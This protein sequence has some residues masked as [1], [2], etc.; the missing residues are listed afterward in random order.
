MGAGR[1][2]VAVEVAVAVDVALALA[3]EVGVSVA[4]EVDVLVEVG[5]S[6]LVGVDEEVA[7]AVDVTVWV[8]VAVG[9]GVAVLVAVD[10]EVAVAVAVDVAVR[11]EVAVAVGVGVAVLVGVDE[12]VAVAVAV[13]VAVLVDVDVGVDVPVLVGVGE[14]V[15]VDVVEA[16]GLKSFITSGRKIFTAP[17]VMDPSLADS[18][19]SVPAPETSTATKRIIRIA[20]TRMKAGRS[21]FMATMSECNLSEVSRW[22]GTGPILV[23]AEAVSRAL[24][25]R[26]D[27]ECRSP[28]ISRPSVCI[29]TTAWFVPIQ[30]LLEFRP[31]ASQWRWHEPMRPFYQG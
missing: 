27:Q 23:R 8:D 5:V 31:S 3:V 15:A 30:A 17:S 7:V 21:G 16:T 22:T 19:L 24:G 6:V 9:V 1:V 18:I 26:P 25:P 12:V 20:N 11:V 10:E 13:D 29:H 28:S 14:A 2:A 4:V